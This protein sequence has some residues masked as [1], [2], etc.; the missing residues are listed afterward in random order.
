[1]EQTYARAIS[2]LKQNSITAQV[3]NQTY[4]RTLPSKE[5]YVHQWNWDSA[6]HAM[7]LIYIDEDWAYEEIY[8]LLSGQWHNGLIP[9]I[10]FNPDERKYF[11]GPDVWR[12]DS[13]SGISVQTSGI[14]QPPL[15]AISVLHMYSVAK[16]RKKAG[17]FL[18]NTL[19]R[20]ISYHNH[21]K[22]FRDAENSGLL[23]IVHPWESGTDNSPRWDQSMNAIALDTIPDDVKNLVHTSRTDTMLGD[24][25][26]RPKLED[27]YRY[28]HLV[29]LYRQ[30][31]WDFTKIVKSS[32]FAVKD[33]LFN[34]IWCQANQALDTLLVLVGR[35]EEAQKFRL[36]HQ[37][38]EEAIQS[39][40]D[41]EHEL[42]RNIDVTNGKKEWITEPT[43]AKF[44]PLYAGA[45]GEHHLNV[46]LKKLT[47]THQYY[48]PIPFPSIGLDNPKFD[49]K[50]YWRGPTWPITNLFIIEGLGRYTQHEACQILRDDIVVKTME[51][52]KEH[53][54]YEYYHP[55]HV[56]IS[57][58][59]ALGFGSFSWSAAIYLYLYHKYYLSKR[60]RVS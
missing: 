17:V 18:N 13:A 29:T 11:P 35:E 50:R 60:D 45:V 57:N 12:T 40:W 25:S 3:G 14:T 28:L 48:T 16:D 32:P 5:F 43:I 4:R 15:L 21:L 31:E 53:G 22:H 7:G 26:H 30:W 37:Q 20:L 23:T 1:M 47:N 2:V 49:D 39:T 51:M 36:W 41:E 9:H 33:I 52:I 38:T 34:A 46:L 27:Y 55:L 59:R 8:S 44:M 54:F 58:D 24:T 19:P 42:F 56:K 10:I 6:T